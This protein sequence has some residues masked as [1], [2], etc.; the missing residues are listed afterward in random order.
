MALKKVSRFT[1]SQRRGRPG[2]A[3]GSLFVGG[4][5]QATDHQRTSNAI[6]LAIDAR[7]VKHSFL[8]HNSSAVFAALCETSFNFGLK[9]C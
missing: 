3:P 4:Q 8:R 7:H 6:T 5:N 9:L 2:F 1:Q